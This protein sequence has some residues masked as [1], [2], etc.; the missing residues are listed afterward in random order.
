MHS[1][2][3]LDV[4]D[5]L[6]LHAGQIQRYGGS[7]GL[8]DQ[9]LLESAIAQAS[10]T[11]GGEFLNPDLFMRAACYLF[12]LVKNHPFVDGNKR[13][14]LESALVFL[15]LNDLSVQATDDELVE[16]VLQTISGEAGKQ[17]IAEFFRI[18]CVGH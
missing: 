17:Q 6:E 1:P 5:V 8:R 12:H 9:G 4:D 7:E 11:F 16:L 2:A 18:R 14:G 13:V 10:A 3:F 15:E